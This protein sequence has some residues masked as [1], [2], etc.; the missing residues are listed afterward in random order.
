M[1]TGVLNAKSVVVVDGD[2]NRMTSCRSDGTCNCSVCGKTPLD[3][4]SARL[5]ALGM[6][7]V[8]TEICV[9]STSWMMRLKT[10]LTA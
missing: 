4:P 1:V 3:G 10:L 9:S 2:K 6:Y 5:N 8:W 7:L